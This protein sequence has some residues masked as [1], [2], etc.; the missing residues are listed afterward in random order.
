MLH[1]KIQLPNA[2]QHRWLP[3]LRDLEQEKSLQQV[4]ADVLAALMH[5]LCNPEDPMV[6]DVSMLGKGTMWSFWQVLMGEL[7]H[8]P[9]VFWSRAV[10]SSAEKCTPFEKWFLIC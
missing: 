2:M 6:L 1:L 4:Q 7:Q 10:Q 9:L 8:R 5:E 3:D